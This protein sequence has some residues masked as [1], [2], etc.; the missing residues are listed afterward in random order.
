ME[1]IDPSTIAEIEE[2]ESIGKPDGTI[3]ENSGKPILRIF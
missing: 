2:F 3:I 1:S